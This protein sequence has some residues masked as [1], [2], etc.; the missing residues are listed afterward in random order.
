[1]RAV[2]SS[3]VPNAPSTMYPTLSTIR[4]RTVAWSS[5][6]TVTASLGTNL[7]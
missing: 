4:T 2:P 3:S 6:L 7:G 1:M 5:R